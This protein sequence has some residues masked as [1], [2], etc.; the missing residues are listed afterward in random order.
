MNKRITKVGLSE[1]KTLSVL[2]EHV[3]VSDKGSSHD[4]INTLGIG[5]L[6]LVGSQWREC[7]DD[8]VLV[9]SLGSNLFNNRTVLL[10]DCSHS[11]EGETL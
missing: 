2:D 3:L 11:Q 4:I 6:P 5:L 9:D 1:E 10:T 8:D 7:L